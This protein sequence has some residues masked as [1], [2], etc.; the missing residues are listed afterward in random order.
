MEFIVDKVSEDSFYENLLIGLPKV[1]EK[2]PSV[3][4]LFLERFSP[5]QHNV[6]CAWEQK[7]GVL[8]PEDL[9][10]FYAS[11]NGLLYT[12]NFFYKESASEEDKV[13]GRIEVN[14][15]NDLA[16]IYGYEIKSDPGVNMDGERYELKLGTDSKVF[17]LVNLHD[18]GR[19]TLIYINHRYLPTIWMHNS[20]M[21]FYFLADDFT[22][23]L[24]MCVHHLGIPF[25]Q[26]SF[27]CD[28][29]P[30]W[31]EV[32]SDTSDTMVF[33]LLAPAIL[34]LHKRIEDIRKNNE[35]KFDEEFSDIPLNKIDCNIFRTTRPQQMTSVP[36]TEQS[37][38]PRQAKKK[39]GKAKFPNKLPKKPFNPKK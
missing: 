36:L 25:W 39:H 24:R 15:L 20:A 9:R 8:L 34:P 1:L 17:E 16:Q 22:T 37:L 18:V 12:Y 13:V 14:S 31:S 30:E 28:G 10:S 29:I 23:Y 33:R 19:V 3:S 4:D 2:L 6:I 5:V 11:T 32:K 27:S 38:S 35:Q 7:H 21:K 26:F